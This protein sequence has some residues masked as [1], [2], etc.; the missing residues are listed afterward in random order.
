MALT[1][2]FEAGR[3]QCFQQIDTLINSHS[4]RGSESLCK[5]LRYLAETSLDHQGAAVKEY[6]IATEVLGRSHGFDPQNDSTVRVQAGRLRVK[7]EE[8]YAHEGADDEIVVELPRKSYALTFHVRAP[9]ASP[10]NPVAASRLSAEAER[11]VGRQPSNRGWLIAVLVLSVLLGAALL[12]AFRSRTQ[13]AA[14]PAVPAVYQVFWQR[15][16][17]GTQQ[18]WVIFSNGSFVGR[19]ETGM[20]YFN[21]AGDSGQ[22]ILDHYT[23]VGEV[24]AVHQ[25]D[26]VFVLLNQPLRVKR[27][28]LF[29][30]DDAKNNDLIFVGSPAEN[31]TLLDI[32]STQ[33]FVFQRVTSGPRKGDLAV[34]NVHPEPGEPRLFL[35]ST[36]SLPTTEDYAVVALV[37]GIDPARSVLILA[38]T[39]TFGTQAAAEYVCRQ[40]SLAVLLRRLGVST[41]ADLKPFEALVHVKVV[42]GVPVIT[43]L[44]SV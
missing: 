33:E 21:P 39:T 29:S 34:V 5:L 12:F 40:D 43:D 23:G 16:V 42:H 30:L 35:A 19:P 18:P 26:H 8:Y 28:S 24:L 27:G 14:K 6:Q 13:A 15:F 10:V 31:L 44:V 1:H 36:P 37:P 7:L 9:T 32:P 41:A 2:G 25:L 20:R 38:G 17:G 3:Q 22:F 4:L 11:S